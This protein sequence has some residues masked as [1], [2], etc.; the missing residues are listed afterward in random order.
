M[1]ME[2]IIQVLKVEE[3]IENTKTKVFI[4]FEVSSYPN[5]ENFDRHIFNKEKNKLLVFGNMAEFSLKNIQENSYLFI[6]GDV[7]E[8][9]SDENIFLSDYIE[10][11]R[12]KKGNLKC[13]KDRNN[14]KREH[15]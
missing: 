5:T 2:L 6:K 3:V 4:D 10:V 9:S 11:F 7:V 13:K 8:A 15:I 14:K 1:H 12:D